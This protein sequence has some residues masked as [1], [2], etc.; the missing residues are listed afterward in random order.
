MV[1]ATSR[2]KLTRKV[3]FRCPQKME[4]WMNWNQLFTFLRRVCI[5]RAK[6]IIFKVH[7]FEVHTTLKNKFC[8]S[9]L[10]LNTKESDFYDNLW[11]L[12]VASYLITP[13]I[14]N[15]RLFELQL[16]NAAT[17]EKLSLF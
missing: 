14:V 9:T 16:D 17:T 11:N 3:N 10:S 1:D 6:F 7:I 12:E 15:I 4:Y 2:A 8:G 13:L 5:I